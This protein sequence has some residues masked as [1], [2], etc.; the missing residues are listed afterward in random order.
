M[1]VIAWTPPGSRLGQV[2]LRQPIPSPLDRTTYKLALQ[3]RIDRLIR[4]TDPEEAKALLAEAGQQERLELTPATAAELLVDNSDRLHQLA[5]FPLE[6]LKSPPKHDPETA[7]ALE[8]ET[9]EE[10]LSAL[11]PAERD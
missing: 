11:Y 2:L 10:F 7:L 6:G 3:G 1:G 9:L 4:R 8:E 5:R